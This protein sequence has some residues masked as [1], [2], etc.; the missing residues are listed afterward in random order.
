MRLTEPPQ[1]LS[2][3]DGIQHLLGFPVTDYL[4]ARIDL[5]HRVHAEDRHL[6]PPLLAHDLSSPVGSFNLRLRHQDGRI[7]CVRAEYTKE[8][9][10]G[11]PCIILDLILQY[12]KIPWDSS[13]GGIFSSF[14]SLMDD[15]EDYMYLKDAN[16]VFIGGTRSFS[17]LLDGLPGVVDFT[18]KTVYD[19]HPEPFADI[20]YRLDSQVLNEGVCAHEIQQRTAPDGTNLW[21][22]D[23]KYPL[24]NESGQII[25]LFGICPNITEP[26]ESRNQ[27]R[28]SREL[29][30][31]FI[32]H[33]PAALAM[34]DR[35]MRYIATSRRWIQDF[36]IASPDI[37]GKSHYAV[38]ANTPETW[39]EQHRRA[40][41]G[42]SIVCPENQ[43][44]SIDGARQWVRRELHPW[45]TSSGAI[46]G[47]VIFSEDVTQQ[48]RDR[49]QL[50]LAASVFTNAREGITITDPHG[51]ILDVNDMFTRIT[52][53]TR[54]EAVGKNPRILKSGRQSEEFYQDMWRALRENGHWSG[55]IW[56]KAK[57]GRIYP[58]SLSISAAYDRLGNVLDYIA[59]FSDITLAK[60]REQQMERVPYYDALTNLPNRTLLVDRLRQAMAHS[61]RTQQ[62]LTVACLDLDD[63]RRVN[64]RCGHEAGDNLLMALARRLKMVVREAD[65][66]AR[67]GSDKFVALLLDVGE[68][69]SAR[70]LL[71]RLLATASEPE[72]FGEKG[73]PISASM[74]AVFY[75]QAQDVDAGNLLRQAEQA[76]YHAKLAGKN[77][78]HIFE[79]GEDVV[80]RS[81]QEELDQ[82]RSALQNNEMV[83][84]FQP[85]VHMRTGE[86]AGAEALVRWQHPLR[87]LLLPGA[88][89]PLIEDHSLID[90]LGEWVVDRALAQHEKWRDAGLEIPVSVNIAAHHLQQPGF[91]QRLRAQLGAH[92]TVHP[93]FLELEV[94]ESSTLHDV[95]LVSGV[96]A[97]CR[98]LGV[99]VS[100]DD[101][102]TGY[103]SLTWLRRLPVNILK[104]DKSFVRDMLDNPEDVSILEGVLGL[105][106]GLDRIAVAEGV[107]TV[108]HG[109]LLLQLGCVFAQGYGIAWPMPPDALPAWVAS[110]KPDPLWRATSRLSAQKRILLQAAIAH[111]AWATAMES[112]LSG[113]RNAP[114]PHDPEKCRFGRWL[115]S[116]RATP[117]GALPVFAAIDAIHNQVHHFAASVGSGTLSTTGDAASQALADLRTLS[118]DFLDQLDG[119]L[120]DPTFLN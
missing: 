117:T 16:H 115:D 46:G 45:H 2:A 19:L 76:M 101:F 78:C 53:Y 50:E 26:I 95:A 84:H 89:L 116:E 81:S 79:P 62:L 63:F 55:E 35:D 58:E 11:S 118:C 93:C 8:R 96:L 104:I 15:T 113:N 92:P 4:S 37:V 49:E 7:R 31:L 66:L 108:E 36:R 18:G 60:E 73:I 59:H 69:G 97:E 114:P 120:E 68:T 75:P 52:G 90:Q 107:E 67:V 102:G 83:L 64:E 22:D 65:T 32:E 3:T 38:F 98:D 82:V 57:D 111:R 112:F 29:M 30:R 87:G 100:L 72:P 28:E 85:R 27:L 6:L 10:T 1:V 106:E 14:R 44:V 5:L 41:A 94:L 86:I 119:L 88:F 77:R 109:R 48:V 47:I 34:L 56:N 71:D 99:S 17:T 39:K 74:G 70:G 42:E 40:L 110:W 61:R 43:L 9:E 51:T 23:R 103:S 24:R 13:L 80:A 25:G 12:A 33:A 91:S 105:A 21:I 20:L 54:E